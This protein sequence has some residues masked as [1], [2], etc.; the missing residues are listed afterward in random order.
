M[1]EYYERVF[2]LISDKA[3]WIQ[4]SS[5]S[6]NDL[7]LMMSGSNSFSYFIL[8]SEKLDYEFKSPNDY[9]IYLS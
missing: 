4:G 8:K 3:S 6:A 9:Y 1:T 2:G 7:M 5:G